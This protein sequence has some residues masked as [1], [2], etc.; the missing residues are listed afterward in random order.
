MAPLAQSAFNEQ[1]TATTEYFADSE[2]IRRTTIARAAAAAEDAADA[3]YRRYVKAT[4]K[5]A[6]DR[7]RYARKKIANA[8]EHIR[9][10]RPWWLRWLPIR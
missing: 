9:Q 1:P 3:E 5:A 6:R 10:L 7:A 4:R 2:R 8:R